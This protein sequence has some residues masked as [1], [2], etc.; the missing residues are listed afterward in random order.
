MKIRQ[1]IIN[2]SAA[3]AEFNIKMAKE[4]EDLDLMPDVINAGVI[5]MIKNPQMGF[6]LV[7]EEDN[8]IQASLMVTTEW[9]DWRNG[10]FWWI[11]SVYVQ[12]KLRRKGLYSKLY[13][14]VKTLAE[15]ESNVCGFRLYVEHENLV[16]QQ[17]YRTLG[18]DKTDYQ[19]FEEMK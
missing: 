4:T 11:Q 18:M 1:A 9:S 15:A 13:E 12:P 2:D 3:I 10:L 16:A 6:Y 8:V 17:T 19:M 7:A 5:N 14:K